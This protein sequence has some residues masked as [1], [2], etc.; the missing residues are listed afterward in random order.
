MKG[1]PGL[2]FSTCN[3][4]IVFDEI[5]YNSD[6]LMDAGDWIELWNRSGGNINLNGWSFKDSNN[7]NFFFF[8]TNT[9]LAPGARLVLVHD[10][11]RFLERHPGA[12]NWIGNFDFNLSNDGELVRLYD[13]SGRLKF[14][15]VFN[16]QGGGWPPG[17][18]GDGYTLELLNAQGNM[19]VASNWFTGCLEGSPGYAYDP[20]CNVGIANVPAKEFSL[21]YS[22]ADETVYFSEGEWMR[23]QSPRVFLF[24]A[25]GRKI[26]ESLLRHERGI[27]VRGLSPGLYLA[28]IQ[29]AQQVFTGKF[30]RQ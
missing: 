5:N 20:D 10:S 23:D 18:D 19:N 12:V 7:D 27:S 1:S 4:A 14:S 26:S 6:T 22:A 17:A 30:I 2:P 29:T 28:A 13:F 3:D 9:N 16:D 15:I 24:D 21:F 8:P 11:V 25:S